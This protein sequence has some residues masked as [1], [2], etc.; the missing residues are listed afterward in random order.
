MTQDYDWYAQ[1]EDALRAVI[2]AAPKAKR[3]ALSAA[4]VMPPDIDDDDILGMID[5]AL[6]DDLPK[7]EDKKAVMDFSVPESF[8]FACGDKMDAAVNIDGTS[9]PHEGC[10]TVCLRCGHVMAFAA[11]LKLR[12][13]TE[14]EMYNIAGD[15]Q[16]LAIQQVRGTL[17][18]EKK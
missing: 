17:M 2:R 6:Q 4:M 5:A 3:N 12:E 16:L 14:L 8:C 13:L 7:E 9:A 1:F 10:L 11:D 15:P 18:K